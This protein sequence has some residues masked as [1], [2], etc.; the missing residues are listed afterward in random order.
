MFK[1]FMTISGH[2][3]RLQPP[4][5]PLKWLKGGS[6]AMQEYKSFKSYRGNNVIFV[7]IKINKNRKLI[8]V[9]LLIMK[10]VTIISH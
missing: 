7:H 1:L 6:G 4:P 9:F 10:Q 5:P 2:A 8:S 3:C